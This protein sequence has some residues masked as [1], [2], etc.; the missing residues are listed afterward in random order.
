MFES[1]VSWLTTQISLQKSFG[2]NATRR[3]N[4]H[5]FF[6]PVSVYQTSNGYVYLAVGNDRQWQSMVA[7]APF[8]SLDKPE[9]E[10]NKGRIRDVEQLNRDIN[11]ITRNYT[12][13]EL[14]ELF[15]A[16][17][18]PISKIK[19]IPEVVDDPLVKKSIITATDPE[20]GTT[21]HLTPPPNMT[22]FLEQNGQ[23]MNFPPRFGE[24]N[25]EIYGDTLG[26]PHE[27]LAA[28]KEKG[29]I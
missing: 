8:A 21:L 4:T 6:S 24:H 1:S 7:Q 17:T 9:Y 23:S 16:I 25:A 12:S 28:L 22:P 15:T 5:E 14:I 10:K 3:G 27:K 2:R 18:V 29:I 13:E 19:T 26:Y 11:A 20:S